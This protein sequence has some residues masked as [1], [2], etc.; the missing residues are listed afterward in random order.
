VA[1]A[2][3]DPGASNRVVIGASS[4]DGHGAPRSTDPMSVSLLDPSQLNPAAMAAIG[5]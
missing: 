4:G 3:C 2:V 5:R 1:D